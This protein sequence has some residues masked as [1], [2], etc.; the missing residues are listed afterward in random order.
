M[1]AAEE[2]QREALPAT[3]IPPAIGISPFSLSSRQP[4]TLPPLD[5][6]PLPPFA[7]RLGRLGRRRRRR[8]RLR[9]R[10]GRLCRHPTSSS[11]CVHLCFDAL[12]H[13]HV[14]HKHTRDTSSGRRTCRDACARLLSPSR[15]HFA[16]V[17]KNGP[18]HRG[19]LAFPSLF[20]V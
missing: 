5:R 3:R 18:A 19:N 13:E 10:L 7:R 6:A 9:P 4:P 16:R 14:K 17:K 8:R 12:I 11:P 1:P 20:P 2:R 15:L